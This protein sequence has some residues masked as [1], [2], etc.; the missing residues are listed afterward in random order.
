[1]SKIEVIY[2]NTSPQFANMWTE[3]GHEQ[4][5]LEENWVR[6]P[7]RRPIPVSMIWGKDIPIKLRDG[8]T[9]Y[10]DV[11]RPIGSEEESVSAIL[12]WSP[13][14]KTGTGHLGLDMMPW[15]VGVPKDKTSDLESFEGLDPAEWIQRGYAVVNVDAR[16][17]FY[18]EGDIQQWGSQEA[19][20]GYDTIEWIAEQKW[21]NGSVGM[22]GN[23]WLATAQWY[24]HFSRKAKL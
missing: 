1:M 7:G 14:G 11:F 4:R 15:R 23:S 16:G 10:G 6:E 13:Y 9:L 2:T 22:A 18:S 20:D 8:T 5:I 12:T 17:V 19:R 3:F 24:I 21:C